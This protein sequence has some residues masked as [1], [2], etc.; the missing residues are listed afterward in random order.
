MINIIGLGPGGRDSLTIGALEVL[1]NSQII[2]CRT[3]K[4]PL[5]SYMKELQKK[6]E[7]YD[8]LYDKSENFDDVYQAIAEDIIC[9]HEK[10]NNLVYA[11]PGHPLVGEKSVL[12][13]IEL[14]KKNSIEYKISPAISIIDKMIET[15]EIDPTDGLKIID[16]FD[17]NNE[18]LDK[19][20][21]IIITQIY[22]GLIASEVKLKLS[23]YYDDEME[24]IYF[25]D[26]GIGK[27]EELR[28]IPIYELDMQDDIDFL[29]A[30]YIPKDKDGKK[31]VYDLINL[32]DILRGEDGCPWDKE[33]TH[34]S[35]KS[36]MIE[37]CYEVVDAIEKEDTDALTEELG[38]VLFQVVFHAAIEKEEGYFNFNDVV[39]GVYDKMVYRHPH[40]FSNNKIDK[41]E[42]VLIN[43]DKLKKKE[44]N[45]ISNTDE[46]KGVATALPAL[47]RAKKVQSKASKLG[48]DFDNLSLACEKV[49]EELI[50]VLDVYKT[51]NQAK[52]IEEM[53]DLLFSCVNVAR[54]LNVNG[55]EALQKTT[56]KFIERFQYIEESIKAEG[57]KIEEATMA[58]MDYYWEKSKKNKK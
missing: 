2:L 25:S 51:N 32:V 30:V 1:K 37:E 16:A 55:E 15:L 19:R 49:K 20:T 12:N 21:N 46:L 14:C 42:D 26:A 28:S 13:L 50:E 31:D 53:G 36:S 3:E 10:T 22:N 52:I 38:D 57:K 56:N 27:K 40:V 5:I 48:F 33:Q 34:Q 4:H 24:I 6:I 18:I 54:F 47:I 8:Y 58:E 43:W 44:K 9:R 39:Q 35:I 23:E 11:V 29:T 7:T 17:I 45:Y 41:T